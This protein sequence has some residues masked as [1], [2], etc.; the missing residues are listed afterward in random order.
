[1]IGALAILAIAAWFYLTAERRQ[2]PALAW[3]VA[4]VIVY[5]GGFAFWMYL[6]L[7]PILGERFRNH[8]LWL[9][10]GMD[11]SAVLVGVL[12]AALFRAFVM[13]KKGRPPFGQSF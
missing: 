3:C 12:F 11:L 5:Y 9:G 8:G 2:L 6:V 4:G 13:L 1:M 10:L 7:S